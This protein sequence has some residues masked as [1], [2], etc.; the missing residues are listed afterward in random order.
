MSKCKKIAL[1]LKTKIAP[2]LRI[3][4]IDCEIISNRS[5]RICN[6]SNTFSGLFPLSKDPKRQRIV[7]GYRDFVR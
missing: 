2:I 7:H 3:K 5:M 1:I 6:A 4:M